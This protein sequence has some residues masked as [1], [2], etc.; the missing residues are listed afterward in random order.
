M[1]LR[2]EENMR[3]AFQGP[4]KVGPFDISSS[5]AQEMINTPNVHGKSNLEVLSPWVNGR[6]IANRPRGMWMIDFRDIPLEE[7]ALYEAPFE[8]VKR[9]VRPVRENNRNTRRRTYW[10]LIGSSV[11]DLR[12]ALRPLDRYVAT[13]RVAK[14]R[15]FVW[16][17]GKVLPDSAI[18]AIARDDDQ[19]FGVLHSRIHEVWSRAM[20]TQ[21]REAES[22][23]RYSHTATFETFPFPRPT[24]E[25]QEAIAE[26]ARELNRLR[27]GWLNPVDAEG[28]PV[29]FGVDLR[30]ADAD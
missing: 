12:T 5:L 9:H 8:Y 23:F 19:T 13:P 4:V 26:A 25:Q 30:R 24:D 11:S 3:V 18:V 17:D 22:G 2:L 28:E 6:D 14:H 15:L 20:G 21:L 29:V 16:L 7:A 1:A 10:W 27:E